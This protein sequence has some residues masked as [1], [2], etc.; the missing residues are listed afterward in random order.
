MYRVI[1]LDDGL[2]GYNTQVMTN[3]PVAFGSKYLFHRLVQTKAD[4]N[5]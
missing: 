1:P 4:R 2:F 3:L 5:M